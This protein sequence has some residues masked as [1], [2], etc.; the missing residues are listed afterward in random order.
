M[1]DKLEETV[2]DNEAKTQGLK[3][4]E[5]YVLTHNR[6]NTYLVLIFSELNKAQIQIKPYSDSQHYETELLISFK[7]L[8]LLKPNKHPEDYYTRGPNVNSFQIEIEDK[9]YIYGEKQYLVL[10]RLIR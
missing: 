5:T 7:D 6:F 3:N 2:H 8:N 9:N 4:P 1:T 10:E